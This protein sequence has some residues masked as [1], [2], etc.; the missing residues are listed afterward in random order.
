MLSLVTLQIPLRRAPDRPGRGEMTSARVHIPG[1]TRGRRPRSV[2]AGLALVL[3]LPLLA[4][5]ADPD[6]SATTCADFLARSKAE[7]IELLKQDAHARAVA[8]EY[9]ARVGGENAAWKQLAEEFATQCT[10]DANT[11]GVPDH[12]DRP[13]INRD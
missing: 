6:A 1:H 11:D 5:C 7:R 12:P 13:L 3:S 2:L 9:A 10:T 8:T 4:G